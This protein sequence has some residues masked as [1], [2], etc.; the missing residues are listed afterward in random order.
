M[1][2][3]NKIDDLNKLENS[4]EI[5]ENV[6]DNKIKDRTLESVIS[7]RRLETIIKKLKQLIEIERF[8][9]EKDI[10]PDQLRF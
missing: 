5:L 6:Y 7:I 9:Y 2:F 3:V 10:D 8:G 4:L 1:N